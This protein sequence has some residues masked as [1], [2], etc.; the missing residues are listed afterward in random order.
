MAR[1]QDPG[2]GGGA[3]LSLFLLSALLPGVPRLGRKVEAS[4]GNEQSG[5]IFCPWTPTGASPITAPEVPAQFS[6]GALSRKKVKL[7][8]PTVRRSTLRADRDR[9]TSH[10]RPGA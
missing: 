8:G 9:G 5:D 7:R 4:K 1:D 6:L 3:P 2:F 10:L